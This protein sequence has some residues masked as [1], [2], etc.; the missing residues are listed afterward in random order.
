MSARVRHVAAR[1]LA[2]NVWTV[3]DPAEL[4]YLATLG[5]DGI[6]TNRPRQ[7]R[8]ALGACGRSVE[9]DAGRHAS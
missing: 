7:A 5:V 6:I 8:A 3:D 1:G 4:R 2:V 9:G